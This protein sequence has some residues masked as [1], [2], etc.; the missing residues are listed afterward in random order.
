M[1]W[2]VRVLKVFTLSLIASLRKVIK[3]NK[4][5]NRV[6]HIVKYSQTNQNKGGMMRSI[7]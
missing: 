1:K 2:T 7:A 3:L 4:A 6:V 5:N